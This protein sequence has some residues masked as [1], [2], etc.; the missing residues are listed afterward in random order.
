VGIL[1]IESA[2]DGFDPSEQPLVAW[3]IRA[4]DSH[5][6]RLE[7]AQGDGLFN[8]EQHLVTGALDLGVVQAEVVVERDLLDFARLK[9]F[10]CLLGRL[11]PD[12]ARLRLAQVVEPDSQRP[13]VQ[14]GIA[15]PSM[16]ADSL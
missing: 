13:G 7:T 15:R 2:L 14:N 11:D 4:V 12:P 8:P 1:F 16:Q 5:R 6:G 3:G 9:Q 10:D